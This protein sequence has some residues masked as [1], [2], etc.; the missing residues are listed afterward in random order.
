MLVVDGGGELGVLCVAEAGV[1]CVVD[2]RACVVLD[3][4]PHPTRASPL[5][6]IAAASHPRIMSLRLVARGQA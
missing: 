4:P 5:R 3:D 1:L 2:A 6:T